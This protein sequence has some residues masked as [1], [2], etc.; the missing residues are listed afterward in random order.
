[1]HLKNNQI[2]TLQLLEGIG[3]AAIKA[4]DSYICDNEVAVENT[5]DLW[6][7]MQ[8]AIPGKVKKITYDDIVSQ[9]TA[10]QRIIDASLQKD[11]KL[12]GCWDKDFPEM[13]KNV[14]DE[15]GKSKPCVLL[16]Y[17]G[18]LDAMKKPGFAIIGTR[19]PD[20]DGLKAGPYFAHA[21]AQQ[22]LNIVSGLALGCDTMAH[23]GALDVGG[24]TTAFLAHGLDSVYPPEN[25]SLAEEIVANGGLLLSEYP[26]GTT[27]SRYNLVARDRLQSA[28]SKAC[29]VIETGLN[30]G[31]MHAAR[32]T[33]A[34]NKTLYVV[35]YSDKSGDAKKGNEWLVTKGAK[36]LTSKDDIAKIAEEIKAVG[37]R[38]TNPQ[39]DLFA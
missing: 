24:T 15:E 19:E 36:R 23:R 38:N 27:V 3:P 5:S 14:T 18:N 29:L 34:A 1:M 16:F 13:L 26:I 20:E 2:L 10:A 39:M 21:L 8:K 9:T 12:L 17:K 30:G 28:L 33:L 31:T 22:G 6:D 11:I 7:V 4:L 35:D 37:D 32:A 25:E